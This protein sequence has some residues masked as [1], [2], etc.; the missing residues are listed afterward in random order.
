MW[1]KTLSAFPFESLFAFN[2]LLITNHDFCHLIILDIIVGHLGNLCRCYCM[3]ILYVIVEIAI[4]QAVEIK[5]IQLPDNA[6]GRR[7]LQHENTRFIVL[8]PLQFFF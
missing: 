4:R 1:L 8:Y 3:N 2:L 6:C 7:I 5:K